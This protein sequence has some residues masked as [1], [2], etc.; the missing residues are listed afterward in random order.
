[1][2]FE[3]VFVSNLRCLDRIEFVPAGGTSLVCGPNGS[4]KTSL[5]EALALAAQG[6]SFLTTRSG[7]LVR[8]GQ[9][10]LRV[11][12][13][14]V[15]GDGLVRRVKVT[16]ERGATQIELDGQPVMA[17]ST[18][19]R[20][21]PLLVVNSQAADLLTGGPSHRRALVDRTMFHV[22]HRYVE[23]WKRYRQALRQRNMLIRAGRRPDEADFWNAEMVRTAESI[24]GGRRD[25]VKAINRS[26]KANGLLEPLGPLAFEYRAGWHPDRSLLEQLEAGWERDV[27]AGF[28][29]LGAHRADLTLK[30]GGVTVGQ[31]LSRGQCKAVACAVVAAIGSFIAELAGVNPVLLIDDLAAELDDNMRAGIVD[32]IATLDGQHIYTAVKTAAMP[33]IADRSEQ[34]FHVEHH[35][36]SATV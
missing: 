19:A 21:V 29:L 25:V 4:G 6:K 23:T 7:D 8:R 35:L 22:E 34:V 30:S 14:L 17:A 27:A 26:L 20:L 24:D 5:L 1:M 10:A 31:R 32:M 28:T 11:K 15:G 3:S 36:R 33:E 12:A 13:A 18:L 16:K 9:G 2:R